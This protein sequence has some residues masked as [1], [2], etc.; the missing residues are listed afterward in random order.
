MS[1]AYRISR[2][3][4]RGAFRSTLRNA[5]FDNQHGI[6]KAERLVGGADINGLGVVDGRLREQ[7]EIR[8]M[9]QSI[10][11]GLHVGEAIAE[12]GSHADGI[13]EHSM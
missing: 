5:G 8:I 11:G 1:P 4:G 10:P 13:F 6:Q 12:I 3:M 2:S 7:G 9:Q